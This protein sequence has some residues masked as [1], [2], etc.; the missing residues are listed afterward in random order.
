MGDV[1]G[2]RLL[3]LLGSLLLTSALVVTVAGCGN[4]SPTPSPAITP[5]PSPSPSASPGQGADAA[6]ALAAFRELLSRSDLSYHLDQTEAAETTSADVVGND[7]AL[8]S[9]SPSGSWRSIAIGGTTWVREDDTWATRA[10]DA[11]WD[12]ID[13]TDPWRFLGPLEGL[14]F[15]GTE[16]DGSL[17]YVGRLPIAFDPGSMRA[18][19]QTG[20]VTQAE[21]WLQPDGTPLGMVVEAD[22]L[23]STITRT[24]SF[25]DMGQALNLGQ[26]GP[27]PTPAPSLT[28]SEDQAAAAAALGAFAKLTAR[29][30][31][32]Y[33]M[34][35]LAS[36]SV[37]GAPTSDIRLV[38]D[39]KGSDLSGTIIISGNALQ[40]ADVGG[41]VY[42][43]GAS[44]T[45]SE[46][47]DIDP[48]L[49]EDVLDQWRYL[50]P[51]DQLVY[52][53]HDDTFHDL[54]HFHNAAP[55]PY[56]TAAMQADGGQGQIDDLDLELT[57]AGVPQLLTYSATTSAPSD[58]SSPV[59]V[60]VTTTIAYSRVGADITIEAPSVAP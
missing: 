60:A 57:P 3:R 7:V 51:I 10:R 21:L 53:G 15:D 40:V 36:S 8:T 17:R 23:G 39:V 59:P 27:S 38:V 35:E 56:Q 5:G 4:A 33:R 1:A 18:I 19:G 48:G 44:G 22:V 12:S 34:D 26:P 6:A 47:P 11:N 16:S 50:G 32:A 45:W 9:T 28:T 25:S 2:N 55:I 30:D 20:Q 29:N 41:V 42:A 37:S 31:L 14:T 54:L 52:A 43:R 24:T 58:G 13:Y 49:L 46:R